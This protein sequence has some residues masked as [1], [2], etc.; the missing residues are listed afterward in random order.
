MVLASWTELAITLTILE[1]VWIGFAIINRLFLS[2]L[3]H[4]PGPKLAALTS[5]YEFYYD[6]VKPGRFVWKIKA[7][8]AEYGWYYPGPV[9]RN[10]S[11]SRRTYRANHPL[12]DSY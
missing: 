12:G 6:I 3:A 8:H 4:I 1:L 5:W 9:E 10:E 2:S 7:L 11:Y